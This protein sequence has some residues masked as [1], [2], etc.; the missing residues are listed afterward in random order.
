MKRDISEF[1]SKCLVCHQV[2]AEHQ[3][4]VGLLKSLSMTDRKCKGI[5]IDVYFGFERIERN[6][7]VIWFIMDSLTKSS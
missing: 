4:P 2:K 1:I 7:D 6:Y 5:T 3:V